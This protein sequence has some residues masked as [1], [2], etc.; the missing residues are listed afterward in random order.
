MNEKFAYWFRFGV[1]WFTPASFF[2]IASWPNSYW[3][4]GV[5]LIFT[6]F[7]YILQWQKIGDKGYETKF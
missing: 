6:V 2:I 3:L 5:M 1:K 7:S 4:A